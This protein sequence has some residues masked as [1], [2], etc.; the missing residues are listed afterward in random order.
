MGESTILFVH[1]IIDCKPEFREFLMI[2]ES[3]CDKQLIIADII[4]IIISL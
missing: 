1:D 4:L 2:K 3:G